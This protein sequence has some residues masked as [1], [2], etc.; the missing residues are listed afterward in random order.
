MSAPRAYLVSDYLM[1]SAA[2]AAPVP[3]QAPVHIDEWLAN[4]KALH[5][6]LSLLAVVEA[7]MIL[8]DAE[9]DGG[10]AAYPL[11]R[12]PSVLQRELHGALA[13]SLERWLLEPVPTTNSR[14]ED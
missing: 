10:Y 7:Q 11:D 5:E 4:D 8:A 14:L 2:C 13:E 3:Y 1:F 12:R 9:P 6:H